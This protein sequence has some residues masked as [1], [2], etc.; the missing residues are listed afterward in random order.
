MKFEGDIDAPFS[1]LLELAET[2]LLATLA[3]LPSEIREPLQ[4]VPVILEEFPPPEAHIDGIADDQLGVFE[5]RTA[6]DPG[7]L[8][9][10]RIVLWLGNLW[11]ICAGDEAAYR[12]EVRVTLLHEF[13]HFLGWEE[14]DLSDRGL[15]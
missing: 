11:E 14:A 15:E 3:E 8:Q 2:E 10:P 1:H 7:N 4:A 6:C 13:G 12:E 5:G 9:P